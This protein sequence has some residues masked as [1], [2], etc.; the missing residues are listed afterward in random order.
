[1]SDVN[2]NQ[3]IANDN[4]YATFNK[5]KAKGSAGGGE[6]WFEALADAWGSAMDK[7]ADKI[8]ELSNMVQ[9]AGDAADASKQAAHAKLD[10]AVTKEDKQAATA[11]LNA[12]SSGSDQPSVMVKLSAESMKMSFMA[13][14]ESTSMSSTAQ[15]LETMAKKG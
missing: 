1:M 8:T 11:E 2:L 12:A 7:Q 14:S 6:S 4:A 3:Q 10:A 15:A 5:G 13:N 9:G